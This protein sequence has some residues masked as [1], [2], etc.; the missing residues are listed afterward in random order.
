VSL[1]RSIAPVVTDIV[2]LSNLSEQEK[3]AKEIAYTEE[4]LLETLSRLTYLYS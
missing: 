1:F 4:V 3:I 2:V